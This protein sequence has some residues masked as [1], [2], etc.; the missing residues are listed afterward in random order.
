MHDRLIQAL[1]LRRHHEGETVHEGTHRV[2]LRS[3]QE[4][5]DRAR[6]EE[7]SLTAKLAA[8][9]AQHAALLNETL[10]RL[11]QQYAQQWQAKQESQWHAVAKRFEAW[12]EEVHT[13][14]KDA[15]AGLIH[16]YQRQIQQHQ[17]DIQTLRSDVARA[18]E[19]TKE[20]RMQQEHAAARHADELA[21]LQQQLA[22]ARTHQASAPR[23][24]RI[25]S[26]AM[27]V[28]E[29]RIRGEE[30]AAHLAKRVDTQREEQRR[31]RESYES[32]ILNK[33]RELQRYQREVA[34]LVQ[35]MTQLRQL[36]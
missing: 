8:M 28:E 14:D 23:D 12:R 18:E 5:L 17:T 25:A 20:A 4:K 34:M 26:L 31:M 24:Q 33:N 7:T 21:H 3:L 22:V 1:D 27:Q 35:D 16:A 2:A 29:T 32:A 6:A 11:A 13:E 19:A 10:P 30:R 15:S 36:M 9:Q